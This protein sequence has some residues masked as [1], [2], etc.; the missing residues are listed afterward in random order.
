MTE[1][2]WPWHDNPHTVHEMIE[3]THFLFVPQNEEVEVSRT[4][5]GNMREYF[6]RQGFTNVRLSDI[7]PVQMASRPIQMQKPR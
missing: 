1:D 7:G 5:K 2:N 3:D 4:F 6:E